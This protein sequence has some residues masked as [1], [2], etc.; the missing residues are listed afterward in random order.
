MKTRRVARAGIFGCLLL[1]LAHAVFARPLQERCADAERSSLAPTT[2]ITETRLSLD[3]GA[4]LITLYIQSPE[5]SAPIPVLS[6]LRDTL[7]DEDRENDLLRYVW[8][9][10]YAPPTLKQRIAAAIPFL[11]HQVTTRRKADSPPP[12][13]V[14]LADPK[15]PFWGKASR[16]F[17]QNAVLDSRGWTFRAL[18][19][20]TQR[21]LE[22]YREAQIAKALAILSLAE[23]SGGSLLTESE[24][25]RIKAHLSQQSMLSAFLR[26]PTLAELM[27]REEQRS[28]ERRAVNWDFLR[29]RAEEEGLFFEPLGLPGEPPSHAL[30]WISRESLQEHFG[31]RSFNGRFLN[32]KNPWTDER[33][34]RWSGYTKT[35][36]LDA[37]NRRV[38]PEHPEAR[39]VE[40]IPL[41]L[42]GLDFPKIPILL[43]D[44]RS[45]LHV[46]ARDA[47]G[48][49]LADSARY[50]LNLS[51][52]GDLSYLLTRSLLNYVTRKKGIDVNQPSRLK[53]HAEL[54]ALLLADE[55]LDPQ[56]KAVLA[57]KAEKARAS[58]LENSFQYQPVIATRQHEALVR[59]ALQTPMLAR[60]LERDRQREYRRLN[61]GP[62]ARAFFTLAHVLTLG[63]YTHREELTPELRARADLA[64][65]IAFHRARL[66][67]A[68]RRA[69][70]LEEERDLTELRA[71]VEFLRTHAALAGPE[72]VGLLK[73]VFLRSHDTELRWHCLRALAEIRSEKAQ[74]VLLALEREA[75]P[76]LRDLLARERAM[77]ESAISSSNGSARS[78]SNGSEFREP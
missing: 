55:Q 31:R 9:Y 77:R 21:N 45:A 11:Y 1:G 41:A 50:L 28:R 71:S 34:L 5:H 30:L 75:D 49:V 51:P 35:I 76:A 26:E 67:A 40:L 74:R 53:A 18:P 4:E 20:T 29:Q 60:R 25:A 68:V 69:I 58:V 59:A 24:I 33:L 47:S 46:K 52:Y 27:S 56:L 37:E 6:V 44:F 38:T 72:I 66:E 13:A 12:I 73:A 3:D 19:R 54:S 32:I 64:R 36:F 48:K 57:R 7:G 61:H 70:R 62:L 16:L 22:E 65:R 10:T 39:A 63:R 2:R 8:I 42:Y 17:V 15:R 78:L 14:D 43:A 23:K